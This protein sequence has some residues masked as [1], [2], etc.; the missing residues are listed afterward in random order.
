M[1]YLIME[2]K[3][4]LIFRKAFLTKELVCLRLARSN[5]LKSKILGIEEIDSKILL[6]TTTL[7]QIQIKLDA[8]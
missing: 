5:N 1:F 8:L 7:S 2:D 3:A 4:S 6:I